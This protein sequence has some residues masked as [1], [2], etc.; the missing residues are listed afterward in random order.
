MHL[1]RANSRL[2]ALLDAADERF[3]RYSLQTERRLLV[4]YRRALDEVK[5]KIAVA[6]VPDLGTLKTRTRRYMRLTS[7]EKQIIEEIRLL[8]G[9]TM[10]LTGNGIKE[11]FTTAA[12]STGQAFEEVAGVS[13]D[14]S[15]VNTGG[16]RFAA[17]DTQWLDALKKHN[18]EL[19][20]DVTNEFET[21]LRTNARQE[22]ISGLVEGKPY[23]AVTKAIE[24]R[25]G[26][27]AGRA[28]TIA[29]T[30]MHKAQSAGRLDG[31]KRG[32]EE[33]AKIGIK[34]FKVWAH[35][36]IGEPRP[37][38]LAADGQK[39]LP[40]EQFNIGGVM[41]DAPG[42]GGGPEDVINCHCSTSL[43]LENME[44]K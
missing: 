26:V 3:E 4:A 32:A 20:A 13:L 19:L 6:F 8:T 24:E 23:R 17:K 29:F 7:I 22:V 42:I 16:T 21:A 31:I 35:N 1:P 2:N 33:A 10:K 15:M 12:N 41:M 40:D 9:V 38:H 18:G 37:E 39:V 28:K 34:T 14:F 44:G 11:S 25:F 43:V 5:A 27:A 30:E 36:P